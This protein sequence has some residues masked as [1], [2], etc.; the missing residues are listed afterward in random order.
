M[1][2]A[3]RPLVTLLAL[4]VIGGTIAAG[5]ASR[6]GPSFVQTMMAAGQ[7][8]GTPAN[9]QAGEAAARTQCATCHKVPPP[10][11]LPR[12]IWR[13]EVA[14]MFLI[15]N[16]QPE[17]AGPPG[18]AARMVLLPPDWQAIVRYYESGAPDKL[19]PPEKWPA[20]DRK[21]PFRR[22]VVTPPQSPPSPSIANVRL[23]DL[24]GDGRLEVVASDMRFGSVMTFKPSDPQPQVRQLA[25]LPNPSHIEPVDYDKDGVLDF[26]VGDL[27]QF[28]PADHNKGAVVWLRGRK[29]GTYA[30]L[31]LDGWPRVSDVEA[32]DFDGDGRLDLAVAA[33]G[34]RRTGN[35][36]V[37]KNETVSYD[38]PSFTP[39]IVDK[40][41]GAIHAPIAD[42]NKDGRPDVIVLFAQESEAVV[43]FLNTGPG[44]RFEPKTIYEGPHPNW[45]SSGI[46]VV[47]LD[48]DG[49]LDV[50]L[51]HGDTFD[52][53]ILKPYHGIQWLENTGGFPFVAHGLAT[54]PGVHR[55]EAA[56]LDDDGDLDIVACALVSSDDPETATLPAL[57]W[58]EQTR[59]GVF[60]RHVIEVGL[61][62][63]ATL[64]A[65][66]YDKDGDIDLVV[67]QFSFGPPVE[68]WFE[69]FE[70][71][72]VRR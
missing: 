65:G 52:D 54:L 21:I 9:A 13:D 39:T 2:H 7:A 71:L 49:D 6:V 29:D 4:A 64:A 31:S 15:R 53:K 68:G 72:R 17:P 28:L 18:T 8:A 47:D 67:G 59:P 1:P 37:L 14:R 24:D 11:V 57:V 19:P 25:Q 43:A 3:P 69:V 56:D 51:T 30:P 40:R 23:V 60:E 38:R 5:F 27:G 22:R 36:T 33:F 16:N 48:K 44:I 10:D 20:A 55:A 63:H 62:T 35:F 26:L 12:A 50:L 34:W 45:G 46:E 58:L 61:P 32:A 70:N 66:D 42:L 41:T